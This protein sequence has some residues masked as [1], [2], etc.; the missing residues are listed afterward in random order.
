MQSRS[1]VIPIIQRDY[2]QGSTGEETT[3]VRQRFVQAIFEAISEALAAANEV[4]ALDLDF[5]Y[6]YHSH[7]STGQEFYPIDGQQSLTTLWLLFWYV[8]ARKA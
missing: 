7:G 1:V 4:P 5:I 3:A 6:G 8:A 2:A